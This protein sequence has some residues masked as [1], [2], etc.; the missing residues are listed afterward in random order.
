[1]LRKLI[2]AGLLLVA[3]GLVQNARSAEIEKSE[4]ITETFTFKNT[5]GNTVVI[6]NIWGA[7]HV[8]GYPGS[9]VQLKIVKT[10]K[11]NSEVF[12]AQAQKEVV[13]EI[14]RADSLLDLYVDTP[15]RHDRHKER[16]NRE[17]RDR[18][19]DVR[20]DFTLQVP[21][22]TTVELKTVLHGDIYLA[23]TSG[24]YIINNVNGGIKMEQVQGSGDVYAVN[25]NVEV[26]FSRNPRN[27]SRFGSLNGTVKLYFTSDLS[28]D[29]RLKTFNGEIYTD[30]LVSELPLQVIKSTEG[31]MH[32]I[33]KVERTTLVRVK[34]GGPEFSLDGFNGDM[35]IINKNK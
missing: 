20:Y 21:E 34:D 9:E 22:Q 16:R 29:F 24:D 32:K 18:I 6:D 15:S 10:I 27:N 19:Y 11:A 23:K 2:L 1:M 12:F 5:T 35:Y 26:D 14:T 7:I 28:A 31:E 25:G 13:L 3:C 30:F 33:Y 17:W 4:E 8:T